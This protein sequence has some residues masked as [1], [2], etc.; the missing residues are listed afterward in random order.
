MKGK[1]VPLRP[2]GKFKKNVFAFGRFYNS[3]LVIAIVPRFLTD[4]ISVNKLP[5]DEEVWGET[6]ISLP[7]ISITLINVITYERYTDCKKL[8]LGSL[9]KHFPVAL[10]V[11][12]N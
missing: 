8:Y 11:S 4:I 5:L 12:N 3:K 7:E 10:L 9:L 6:Y 1:Y 2:E